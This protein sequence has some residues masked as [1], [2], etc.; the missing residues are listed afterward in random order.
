MPSPYKHLYYVS[1]FVPYFNEGIY[2]VF[3]LVGKPLLIVN[4]L[5]GPQFIHCAAE[6]SWIKEIIGSSEPASVIVEKIKQLGLEKGRIGV[7]G[8]RLGLFPASVY[9]ILREKLPAASFCDA[10][11]AFEEAMNEVSRTSEEELAFLKKACEILDLSFDAVRK[12]LK[13]GVR[14]CELWSAAEQAIISNG[15]WYPHF[16]L[17]TSSRRPIFPRA[18]PSQN[19]LAPGDVVIF[20]IN[21][22]YGGVSLRFAMRFYSASRIVLFKRCSAFAKRFTTM[23][24]KSLRRIKHSLRLS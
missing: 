8:Y 18:P 13:R 9:D 15:G 2:V 24:L 4:D 21:A 7:V 17:A 1:N 19:I 22:T 6:T 23:H 10:T 20:E 12:V 11:S 16:I 3:P 5:L 14:E